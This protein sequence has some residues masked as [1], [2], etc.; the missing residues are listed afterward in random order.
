[1]CCSTFLVYVFRTTSDN[2]SSYD[3]AYLLTIIIS[4]CV[5]EVTVSSLLSRAAYSLPVKRSM[6]RMR[7]LWPKPR[8]VASWIVILLLFGGIYPTYASDLDS[9]QRL[10]PFIYGNGKGIT[11]CLFS[12]LHFHL[13]PCV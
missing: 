1:M 7:T 12:Y 9:V 6:T 11:V 2:P 13:V 5:Q 10:M 4:T 8:T 3:F